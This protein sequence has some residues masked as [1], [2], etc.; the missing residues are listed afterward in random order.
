MKEKEFPTAYH[1]LMKNS[2]CNNNKH[3]MVGFYKIRKKYNK[4]QLQKI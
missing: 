2:K 1:Y 3:N 4:I